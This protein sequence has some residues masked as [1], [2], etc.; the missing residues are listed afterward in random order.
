MEKMYIIA[1]I[2]ILATIISMFI[3][4]NSGWNKIWTIVYLLIGVT[5]AVAKDDILA[6]QLPEY[7]NWLRSWWTI[8]GYVTFMAIACANDYEATYR[9]FAPQHMLGLTLSIL[10][11][12]HS[13]FVAA[14]G[15]ALMV[16]FAKKYEED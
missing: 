13:I 10:F 12:W 4:N 3:R 11:F 7:L 6:I 15:G 2:I 9:G 16:V 8:A 14:V 1:A 5:I